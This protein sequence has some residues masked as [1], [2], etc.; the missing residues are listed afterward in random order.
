MARAPYEFTVCKVAEQGRIAAKRITWLADG[1]LSKSDYDNVTWWRFIPAEVASLEAMAD[2]LRS[3]ALKPDRMLVMGEPVNGLNLRRPHRRLWADPAIA[4]LHAVE[5]AWAALDF[6]DVVVPDDMGRPGRLADAAVYVRDRLLPEEFH[7]RRMIAA[8]S[9]MTGLKGTGIARLRLFAAFDQAYP[10][11]V[12]K[13]WANG[14]RAALDIP[15]D[16]APIQAGHPI[17]SGRP[18][19]TDMK[20]SV[21]PRLHATILPGDKDFVTLDALRFAPQAAVIEAKIATAKNTFGKDWRGLLDATLG[22]EAGFFRPLTEGIGLAVRLGAPAGE[23]QA[24]VAAL[25]AGRADAGRRKQ[26][27]PLWVARSVARFQAKD[28][29]TTAAA[30]AAHHKALS[31]IF[32]KEGS[33]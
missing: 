13:D 5:R 24:A 26:Y 9:A 30:E 6:D 16:S 33:V 1:S 25:L 29:A 10:L 14:A 12:L 23:I 20:D 4:T 8:P 17:Y 28:V 7:G 18:V 19:F 3:L 22:G 21:P 15:L 31:R 2:A 11:R 27:G 32:I